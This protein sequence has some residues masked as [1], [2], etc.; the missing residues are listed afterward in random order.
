MITLT[1]KVSASKKAFIEHYEMAI[2]LYDDSKLDAAIPSFRKATEAFLKVYIYNHYGDI[3]GREILDGEKDVYG[4][5]IPSPHKKLLLQDLIETIKNNQIWSNY[6]YGKY[7]SKVKEIQEKSNPYSHDNEDKSSLTRYA[8]VCKITVRELAFVL[9]SDLGE[10]VPQIFYSNTQQV[11]S[12]QLNSDW[13]EFYDFVEG[14]ENRSRYI[15]VAPPS[16]GNCTF[17]ALGIL[18]QVKWS[19]IID[20]NPSSKDTGLYKSFGTD[21]AERSVPLMITQLHDKNISSNSSGRTINWVF[22]NGL[23]TVPETTTDNFKE[24]R[25]K[26]YHK[27]ISNII[28]ESNRNSISRICVVFIDINANYLN[29]IAS[30]LDD[31]EII[32]ND[33]VRI[34]FCSSSIDYQKEAESQLSKYVLDY[35]IFKLSLSEIISKI[36]SVTKYEKV[37]SDIIFVSGKSQDREE[38]VID[39]TNHYYRLFDSGIQVIHHNIAET[40]NE[41]DTPIPEFYKGNK[42][43]WRE[44]SED[45]DVNRGLFDELRNKIVQHLENAK[46]SVKFELYHQPGAGGTTLSRRIAYSLRLKYPVVIINYF[47][48]NNTYEKLSQL[49]GIVKTPLLAIV[50]A[51]DVKEIS[52]MDLIERCNKQKQV[53][54]FVYV[55]R[56]LKRKKN[57]QNNFLLSLSDKIRNNDEKSRFISKLRAYSRDEDIIQFLVNLPV[58]TSEVIDYSLAISQNAYDKSKLNKYVQGYIDQLPED[59]VKFIAYVCI[60]YHYSQLRVSHLL[61]R[62]M[63]KY[64]LE[65][66]LRKDGDRF[67][68]KILVQ[69][70]E[71]GE[72]T[73]YW[74]PRFFVFAE[75]VLNVLL[76]NG[77]DDNSWK[78]QIPIYAKELI[79]TIKENNPILVDESEKILT[80]V[81]LERGNE[82]SLGVETEWNSA[83]FNEQFSLLLKDIGDNAVEQKNILMLLANSFPNKSHFWAHLG[84]FVY[85]KAQVP[86]EYKE[87]LGYIERAFEEGGDFDKSILHV[88]GMCYRREI[89]YYKRNLEEIDFSKLKDLTDISKSYFEKCRQIESSN[90]HA[91]ISEIQLLSCV[92]E[93]GMFISKHNDFRQFLLDLDNNWFLEQYEL[94]NELI[95]DANIVLQQQEQL[96]MSMR[97]LRSR[98]MLQMKESQSKQYMGDYKTS[99][100][101]L[102]KLIEKAPRD[103]RP[104]LRLVYVRSL[105]LSKVKGD[106][107]KL[108]DA[109]PRLNDGECRT[110]NEFLTNNIMQ[111]SSNVYSLRLWFDFVRYSVY[112][113][114]N[115][116]IVS[117]LTMMYDNSEDKSLNKGQAAYYLMIMKSIQLITQGFSVT[118]NVLDEIKKIR[119]ECQHISSYDKFSFEWLQSLNGVKGIVNYKYRTDK[120]DLIELSGTIVDIYSPRQGTIRLD[121]GI[122]AFFVPASNFSKGKDVS[123][124]VMFVVGFRHDGLAAYDVHRENELLHESIIDEEIPEVIESIQPLED[125][126]KEKG[127]VFKT[128]GELSIANSKGP[129]VLGKIDLSTIPKR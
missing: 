76:G 117:R 57:I 47:E 86:D 102:L 34:A 71:N 4:N 121:C 119:E 8:E 90:I 26:K 58:A 69:E 28:E 103:Q 41:T 93:Y 92:L 12:G 48:R 40:C 55:K 124:R 50:E 104:R 66:F 87:A 108:I 98:S 14:F 30:A 15:L 123:E 42:V 51:S 65:D 19:T 22:A 97:F 64:D 35:R 105:L 23:T 54:I 49:I 125:S 91:Y 59:Q 21:M 118:D 56:E 99:L 24:W 62:R 53:V 63:F 111:D 27:F 109:W 96:G 82:D 115:A 61:F 18:H 31:I 127:V 73:E 77:R 46:Q 114:S 116:E 113:V 10:E 101:I 68:L 70:I 80:N 83:I 20:F 100:P 72:A 36:A 78:E 95:D 120:T 112:D 84:R 89:E 106:K 43:S 110:I 128:E 44:L 2:S 25:Q 67:I 17:E 33:L 74:R 7:Y 5:S 6:Q 75:V 52:V 13:N 37:G 9:F 39:I 16:Y 94:M 126:T 38:E 1:P 81:F 3:L 129:V 107:S 29:E 88:A 60:I 85:E 11:V 79:T 122:D 45:V 32:D